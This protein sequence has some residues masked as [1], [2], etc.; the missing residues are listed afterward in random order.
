MG[1]SVLCR[2]AIGLDRAVTE[3]NGKRVCFLQCDIVKDPIT[4]GN[5][6][7]VLLL[8][9]L[10]HVP[11]EDERGLLNKINNYNKYL[12]IN[13]P[14]QQDDKQP[15]DRKVNPLSIINYLSRKNRLHRYQ[16][17]AISKEESYNFMVF[18]K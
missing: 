7:T 12:I 9:V 17:F 16:R 6:D 13:I 14:D 1:V 3:T 8:D 15:Y 10:E 5:I 11:R 2:G 4:Y 18:T